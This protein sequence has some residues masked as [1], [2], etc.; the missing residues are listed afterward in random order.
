MQRSAGRGSLPNRSS[1]IQP[2]RDFLAAETAGGVVVV[3]AAFAALVWANSPWSA[4][5]DTVWQTSV[6]LN[7]G[8]YGFALDLRH[9]VN[10]GL[11][12]LFFFVA[13]LEIKREIVEGELRDRRKAAVPIAA[14]L[15]GMIVPA[16]IYLVFNAGTNNVRG[17]GIPMATDIA[18]AIGVLSLVGPRVSSGAKLFLLAVAIVDDIGAIVVIALFYST[19]GRRAWLLGAMLAIALVLWLQRLGVNAIWVYVSVGIVLWFALHEAG[20]HAT[21]AGVV[22][23]LIAPTKPML[24][25]DLIDVTELTDLSNA[26]HALATAR[27]ARSS[28]SVV[29]WLEHLLHRWT[30][31]LIV[32]LFAL[33]NTGIHLSLGVVG[34]SLSSS[35]TWGII[36]GLV[37]GKPVGILL[38]TLLVVR[39]G[40]G[41]LPDG[42]DWRDLSVAAVVAGIGFTVS[43][44]VAELAFAPPTEEH[45]KIGVVL[46]SILAATAGFALSRQPRS[47][48]S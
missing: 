17:W 22:M 10:D 20:V 14:A 2:L 29:E 32:P 1:L 46:A 13:G 33:A 28:V 21:I 47:R 37:I 27:I 41:A 48:T 36:V 7:I 26:E 43:L 25:E 23:G 19:G 11:M 31:L 38:A 42:T 39:L 16:V 35:A 9:W 6:G 15:G 3:S 45:A 12:A 40:R 8:R 24:H 4:S 34:D 5:Y 18:F 44:F 30:S